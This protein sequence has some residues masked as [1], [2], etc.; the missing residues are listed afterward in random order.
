[1]EEQGNGVPR[2][3]LENQFDSI[4]CIDY[5]QIGLNDFVRWMAH[6]QGRLPP[7]TENLK[8]GLV[9]NNDSTASAEEDLASVTMQQAEQI[10]MR[11]TFT[12]EELCSTPL[13]DDH[14]PASSL[15]GSVCTEQH[16]EP[17]FQLPAKVLCQV[18]E[19]LVAQEPSFKQPIWIGVFD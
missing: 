12:N 7:A 1:M 10:E 14:T 16:G 17:S 3:V 15:T 18:M 11:Q 2:E 9:C 4:A 5:N 13:F 8:Q 19:A 6:V